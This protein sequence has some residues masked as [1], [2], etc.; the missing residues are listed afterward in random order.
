MISWLVASTSLVAAGCSFTPGSE[1]APDARD[2][3]G[4][5]APDARD[6]DALPG[7]CPADYVTIGTQ[8]T[9]YR[10]VE[11]GAPAARTWQDASLD[12]DDDDDGGGFSRFTHLV[13]IG[14]EAER[15]E[16]TEKSMS[17]AIS[18]NTW[19]GFSDLDTEGTTEGTFV[20]VTEEIPAGQPTGDTKPPWDTDDPDDAGG[21]EDCVRFKNGFEFEDKPCSD[22]LSYVCE[23]DGYP[24]R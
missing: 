14:D 8:P 24:R 9:M 12:C 10:V 13:V 20:W 7:T 3:D 15:I 11:G 19:I 23:C 4:P 22:P 2:G 5:G 1:R 17:P 6:G 16:I 18:G 21:V